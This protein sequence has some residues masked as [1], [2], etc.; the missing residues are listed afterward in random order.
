L[1]L[2]VLNKK[3]WLFFKTENGALIG[4]I[5]TSFIKTCEDNKINPFDYFE[6]CLKSR[7]QVREAPE[8]FMPWHLT[9]E[10]MKS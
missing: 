6:W 4:D 1:R 7:N 3:N 8:K 9:H 10:A 5:I 2:P